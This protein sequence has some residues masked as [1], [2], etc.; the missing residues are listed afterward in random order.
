MV[1]SRL[2]PL[3]YLLETED[4]Q[5]WRRHIDQ[6]KSRKPHVTQ[7]SA[8]PVTEWE[9]PEVSRAESDIEPVRDPEPEVDSAG[10]GGDEG[11]D[12]A[13][14]FDTLFTPAEETARYPT[15]NRQVPN[16]R[17]LLMFDFAFIH[18]II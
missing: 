11:V 1:V 8:D 10:N 3:S 5:L 16:Y 6:V 17:Y 7:T 15:R 14:E 13:D 2:G 12:A 4:K 18:A 9:G